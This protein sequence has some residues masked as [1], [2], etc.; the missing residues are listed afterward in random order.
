MPSQRFGRWF[1]ELRV[2]DIH[3][4][5]PGK[6]ITEAEHHIFCLLTMAA[7]PL[8]VDAHY[9]LAHMD[10]GRNIVVGTYVYSLII[11][12]SVPDISGKAIAF[13]GVDEL[14][15]LKPVY[16]GDTLYAESEVISR[17]RSRTQPGAGIVT[18]HSKGLNQEG[19]LVC[20]LKRSIL[21]PLK[22]KV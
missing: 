5:W 17:R 4:H 1:E 20:E 6:T 11:G 15:H 8:H 3:L 21:V 7:S 13:L 14:R 10:K 2:G 9:A 16:H 12:M 22:P 18:V 19:D